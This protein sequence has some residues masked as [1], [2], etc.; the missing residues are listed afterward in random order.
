MLLKMRIILSA[1]YGKVFLLKSNLFQ[2]LLIN[3]L[4]AK[5]LLQF[6]F[7][8]C[9]HRHVVAAVLMQSRLETNLTWHER[10]RK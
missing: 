5:L 1:C 6:V 8:R 7:F 10:S 9:I 4:L 3:L 2:L